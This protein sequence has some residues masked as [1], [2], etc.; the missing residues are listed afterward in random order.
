[1][2]ISSYLL[3][4][5]ATVTTVREPG[6]AEIVELAG[7]AWLVHHLG[8]EEGSAWIPIRRVREFHVDE[9]KPVTLERQSRRRR[10]RSAGK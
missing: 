4:D 7:R 9:V 2:K 5:E 3:E 1:M 8:I 10:Q 6:S